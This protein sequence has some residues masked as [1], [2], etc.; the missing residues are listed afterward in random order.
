[1]SLVDHLA[2][3]RRRVAICILAV[4]VFGALGFWLAPQIITILAD[5]L[6][7]APP[8]QSKLQLITVSGG[9]FLYMR[10]SLV[11]GVLLGL[12][13]ILY[14][15]WAFVA[16]GLTQRERRTTL[17]WIP[18]TVVFFLVGALV[19]YVTLPY[20]IGFLT[21]FEVAGIVNSQ[22][23]AEAYF[24]FVTI[25]FLS[26]GLVMQFPIVLVVLSKLGVLSVERLKASRRY[27]ILGIVVFAVVVTP[28]GDPI[29]P[30]V[31]SAVMYA[32]Y[33]FTILWLTRS[34]RRAVEPG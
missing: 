11:V 9:F 2:E 25:T 5:P 13:V 14:Q 24:G 33:E 6:P 26:F 31:M 4:L 8:G 3:L 18:M 17:P 19:A 16:P 20:A 21:S 34:E 7:P 1:M 30:I 23:T 15:T 22:P 28:G 12:P 27:V 32:L 29:S 10:V